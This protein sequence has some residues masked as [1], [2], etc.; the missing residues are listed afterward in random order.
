MDNNDVLKLNSKKVSNS[1]KIK[2][3]NPLQ[4]QTELADSM[5]QRMNV[6]EQ[7]SQLIP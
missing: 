3:P 7:P 2:N 6:E 1:P 4:V 5:T